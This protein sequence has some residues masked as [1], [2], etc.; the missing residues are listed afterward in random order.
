MKNLIVILSVVA[1]V[2]QAAWYRDYF[3]MVT[4]PHQMKDA[5][6]E[7]IGADAYRASTLYGGW[8]GGW[9]LDW[10]K[11]T[12]FYKSSKLR[13]ERLFERNVMYY[14]GGEVG[15]FLL[16]T[17]PD[18]R[19]AYDAW[20]L[21]TWDMKTPL[22]AHW[23]GVAS[24]FETSNPF[25]YPNA[26]D[27]G[28]RPFTYPD[29]STPTNVYEV[30]GRAHVSGKLDWNEPGMNQQVT[31]E[32]AEK[33][34]L[35][36]VSEKQFWGEHVQGR[37]GWITI[38]QMTQ[39]YAN[40]QLRDYQA[41]ELAHL[42][43]EVKP[44]GWHIDNMGDNNLY[45]P[46]EMGFG[47]WSEHTFREYMKKEF[48]AKELAELG[49]GNIGTFDIKQYLRERKKPDAENIYAAYNESKWKDDL[50]FKCYEINHALQSAD[51]HKAKYGAVK[52]AA[53]ET[54]IDCMV[55][56]NLIPIFAGFTLINGNIDVCHFEW[57][58]TREY[59]PSRRPMG[60]PPKARSGYITRL[61]TAISK[62]NYSV[63]SLYV[64]HNLRGEE[65]KNLYLAQ[66]FEALAN[67]A[68][69]DYGHQYLDMYS[70]GTPETAGIFN[71]FLEEHR[72]ALGR[73]DFVADIGIVYD[74]WAEI[75]SSTACQL[76]VNDFF[77][78]YA[79]WCDYM[80]DT[81]RQ[82][83]V[84]LSSELDYEKI[85]DLPMII[86]PS[87]LSLTD[88]NF[89]ALEKY[90]A[91]GG[92]VL[93]TGKTGLRHGP[94]GHLMKRDSNP[95]ERF[96][97]HK[98]FRWIMQQP[99]A[100]Y[101]LSKDAGSAK[102]M[103]SLMTWP[104]LNPVL[105]TDAEIHVGVTLSRSLPGEP[106]TLSLDLNNNNFDP[107]TDGFTPTRPFR[108]SIRLPDDFKSPVEVLVSEPRK[109]TRSVKFK[110][111]DD[112][113]VITFEPFE[114]VQFVQVRSVEAE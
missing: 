68:V 61:A 36:D 17:D 53:R 95:L 20:N 19:V 22:T 52:T 89:Q 46:F 87:A 112:L 8:Y 62:E 39:D 1:A 72:E 28:L 31:D 48:S 107:E 3:T 26:A 67:R 102:R 98:G 91:N 81:H 16:C 103:N 24:F 5:E 23:F 70:P 13:T 105:E 86:L 109:E 14:D 7:T 90:L 47:V 71:R 58:T 55:S 32:Q 99:A 93:A 57:Q 63:V 49:I 108:V 21:Q 106:K 76:D 35:A 73:R 54:G 78:E 79:G 40:P 29:G 111:N 45:R 44:D 37:N 33:S 64:P 110:K 43:R 27:Y 84:L 113:L 96:K 94:G 34:G 30:L 97:K 4:M 83:N 82:W 88:R 11:T 38:R 66:G 100:N 74:Q 92:R 25:P 114:M 65:H 80:Q 10:Q 41:W 12:S 6:V 104:D 2:S 59:E 56:G 15:E 69:I 9:Y 18:G 85:K 42:T 75:A 101:W 51:F 50:I 77:N 60:L